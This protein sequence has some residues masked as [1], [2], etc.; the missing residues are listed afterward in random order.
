MTT[1]SKLAHER[2]AKTASYRPRKARNVPDSRRC[3]P[4]RRRSRPGSRAARRAAAA[5]APAPGWRPR[6]RR[7]ACRSQLCRYRRARPRR[8]APRTAGGRRAR[9]QEAPRPR[10][11]RG[12]TIT[13]I[14]LPSQIALR[15]QG[16][17][18][19]PSRS[20]CSRSAANARVR[21]SSAVK[22][23]AI[24]SSPVS[25]RSDDPLG[26]AKWKIVSAETTN[27][28]IAGSV[29]RERSS[30]SRSLRASAATSPDVRAHAIA[31]RAVAREASASGS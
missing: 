24:Q 13:P 10:P 6:S 3:W 26:S 1:Y 19:R 30:S 27:N 25:A 28:S 31:S 16:A 11:G 22:T 7:A 15:S 5:A 2:I 14:V 9:R 20:P 17:R 12:T 23:I 4:R 29:S 18:T 21:P 8:R